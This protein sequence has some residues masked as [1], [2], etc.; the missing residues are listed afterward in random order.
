MTEIPQ[1]IRT[2]CRRWG[3]QKRRIWTGKDWHGNVDGYAQ[4]LLGRIR[5]ER[6]GAGQGTSSQRWPEVFWGD[7]LDV[8]RAIVGMP[9]TPYCVLHLQFVFDPDF[10]LSIERRARLLELKRTAYTDA[11]DNA[12]HFL[13]GRMGGDSL[14]DAK[15]TEEVHK[16]VR[17]AFRTA[18]GS[19]IKAQTR[20]KCVSLNLQALNRPTLRRTS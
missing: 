6:E 9:E 17:E 1:W 10:G 18:S 12:E 7:G 15:I 20:A 14:S 3:S 2:A 19:D 5:D 13:M 11:L 16:I 8:Q 4:S